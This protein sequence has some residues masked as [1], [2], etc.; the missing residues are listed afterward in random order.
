MFFDG[1]TSSADVD[2]PLRGIRFFSHSD[3][4]CCGKAMAARVGAAP[5][6]AALDTDR[7]HDRDG[8]YGAGYITCT[9]L[10]HNMTDHVFAPYGLQQAKFQTEALAPF[11]GAFPWSILAAKGKP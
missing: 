6:L 3:L 5:P 1:L 10:P 2:V 7:V 9:I 8:W 11:R 4:R